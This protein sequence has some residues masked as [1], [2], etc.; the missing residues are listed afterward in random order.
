MPLV[1]LTSNPTNKT[2]SIFLAGDAVHTHTPTLGQ[3]MNVSMQDAYNLGWKLCSVLS[4]TSRPEI[5]ATY[6]AERQPVAEHLISLDQEMADFY[7]NGPSRDSEEYQAFRDQFSG[8]L[9]GVTVEY[10]SSVLVAD[11]EG[12]RQLARH[13]T[14]GRRLPLPKVVCQAQAN[15]VR[16]SD[17]LLS[18]GKWRIV[19]LPGNI[20]DAGQLDALQELAPSLEDI[21]GTFN[22]SK[23]NQ[24]PVID[25]IAI[26]AGQRENTELLDLH[27]VYHPWDDKLGWDY[28]RAYADNAAEY[29]AV[30]PVYEQFGV[31]RVRGCLV[32][33]R[34]DQHVS[35]IASMDEAGMLKDHLSRIFVPRPVLN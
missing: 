6:T 24:E 20:D 14:L 1:S 29:E 35:C 31:D 4:G 5:L 3:G 13:L 8:F 16:L 11:K 10:D 32:L 19:V 2:I 28:W 27:P 30:K 12:D 34:P 17:I 33:L 26:H 21:L 22:S 18:D 7:S 23:G 15:I 25:V 9:S